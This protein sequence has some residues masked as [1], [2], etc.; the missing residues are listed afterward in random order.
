M[1]YLTPEIAAL[2]KFANTKTL[3]RSSTSC[4]I[5]QDCDYTEERPKLYHEQL[6]TNK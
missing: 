3:A 2:A 1:K 6:N 4:G 5:F